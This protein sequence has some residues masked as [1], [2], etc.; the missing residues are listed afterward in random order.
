MQTSIQ[1]TA[2]AAAAITDLRARKDA[3]QAIIKHRNF[4]YEDQDR[5]PMYC[6][7]VPAAYGAGTNFIFE[8]IC[9]INESIAQIIKKDL[10]DRNF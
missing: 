10:V 7:N 3:L 5:N 8:A 6:D 9:E 4:P 2:K 1:L